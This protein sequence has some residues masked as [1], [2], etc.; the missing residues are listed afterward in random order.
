MTD[1]AE[2][3]H[4]FPCPGCGSRLAFD[5]GTGELACAHCGHHEPVG[6]HRPSPIVDHAFD[7]A[8]AR[9]KAEP[10][11]GLGRAIQ[12]QCRGCGA[13]SLVE[14]RA[15]RCPFCD[16]PVVIREELLEV[17]TPESV[18]PFA[19]ERRDAG[20][21]FR[22][23]VESRWFAP[24]D[25][26]ARAR[27]RGMDGVY[28]PYWAFDSRTD[29]RYRGQRGRHHYVTVEHTDAEGQRSTKTVRRTRWRRVSG[30]VRRHFRN[31]LVVAS[32]SLPSRMLNRL[33]PWDLD[34]LHP[35]DP[36][37]LSGFFAERYGVDLRSGF[38]GARK[39][40]EPEIR[41]DVC[42][43]IG[44]DAQRI[45]RLDVGHDDVRFK[46]L[47]LPLWIS[48]FRYGDR[49]YRFIVN[50]RTGRAYGE[51]PYSAWKIG[52]AVAAAALVVGVAW[53]LRTNPT[54]PG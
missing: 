7:E 8:V 24:N 37:F 51:R 47:L 45:T 34:A 54:P 3:V 15:T 26:K 29:T 22:R 2:A 4:E 40:M 27:G 18:L 9:A 20:D 11:P 43:D 21:R 39:R 49:V 17:I 14:A 33:E 28:L 19:I 52:I 32:R 6:S 46:H 38:E 48:S 10:S 23:W 5:P 31:V 13:V 41:R 53:W 50:A 1:E 30:Q 35:F 12:I 36:G 44:G 16:A 42:R 25:L